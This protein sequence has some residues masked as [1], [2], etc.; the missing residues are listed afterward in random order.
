[1]VQ[2]SWLAATPPSRVSPHI[3]CPNWV[4]APLPVLFLSPCRAS[5]GSSLC[6]VASLCPRLASLGWLA[7]WLSRLGWLAGW[8]AGLAG[9]WLDAWKLETLFLESHTLDALKGSADSS[10]K[11][12]QLNQPLIKSVIN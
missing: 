10:I 9:C 8:L 4:P 3:P 5:L 12:E 7:G 1:M 11:Y 6:P 2:R